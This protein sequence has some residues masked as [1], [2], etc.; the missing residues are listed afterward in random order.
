LTEEEIVE[1]IRKICELNWSRT[2]GVDFIQEEDLYGSISQYDAILERVMADYPSVRLWK[3]Y[4]A[5]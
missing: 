3:C 1:K 5:G 2:I 4:H